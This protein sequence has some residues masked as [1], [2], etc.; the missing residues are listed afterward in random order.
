MSK[1]VIISGE[2]IMYA[3]AAILVLAY[4][5]WRNDATRG[6]IQK[7]ALFFDILM[8][9]VSIGVIISMFYLFE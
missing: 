2:Y 5:L 7:H 4:L 6:F 9:S 3:L 1:P 8:I